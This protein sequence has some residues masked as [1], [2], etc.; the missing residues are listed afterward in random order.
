MLVLDSL[1]NLLAPVVLG[2]VNLDAFAPK[3]RGARIDRAGLERAHQLMTRFLIRATYGDM[4]DDQQ[5]HVMHTE[6]RIGVGHLG[7][8]GFLAKQGIRYSDAPYR[9]DVR[10]LLN[11]LYDV[12][13]EEAREYAF[14]LRVPEPVKVTTEAPTGSIAK[15]P[16]VTEGIHPIYARHFKRRVRFS[17][18]DPAQ[19]KTVE[20]AVLAGFEVE[21]CIYD[22]SGNTMVVTYPTKDKLVAEAAAIIQSWLPDLKGTTLMPDGTRAQAPYERITE[23]EFAQYAVTSVEDV[24]DEE[25]STGACPVR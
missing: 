4:T 12:V 24:T 5:R 1:A 13:R 19:A 2:H 17:M 23:E 7:V 14:Q 9:Y 6:R 25:C 20:D 18:P 10:N 8:Q 22:Q 15:M 16:G 21:K 11:D 3:V